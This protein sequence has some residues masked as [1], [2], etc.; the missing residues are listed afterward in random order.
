M[1]VIFDLDGTLALCDHRRHHLQ[2]T[3]KDWDAFY[4]ACDKDVPNLPVLAVMELLMADPYCRVEIW[5]GR[6]ASEREKTLLWFS[7]VLDGPAPKMVMRPHKDHSPDDA[8]KARWLD[9][10][11]AAGGPM[12][13]LVFDDRDRMVAMWRARGIVCCQVA[14][15]AF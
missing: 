9:E 8:L 6:R 3:P 14:P 5:S 2:K 15:G 12:P 7:G 1:F 11:L 4:A 10:H 13:S